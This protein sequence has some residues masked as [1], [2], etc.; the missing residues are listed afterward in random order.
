MNDYCAEWVRFSDGWFDFYFCSKCGYRIKPILVDIE[1]LPTV[2]PSC[3][4]FMIKE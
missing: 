3:N 4:R 2:C 1:L